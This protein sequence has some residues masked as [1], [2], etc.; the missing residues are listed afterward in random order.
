M[1][2]ATQAIGA[3]ILL[4][5]IASIILDPENTRGIPYIGNAVRIARAGIGAY[6][7]TT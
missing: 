7:L 2:T 1:I 6:L 4:D 3:L 5:G